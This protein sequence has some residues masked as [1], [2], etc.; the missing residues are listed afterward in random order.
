VTAIT[1][2][3]PQRSGWAIAQGDQVG[4]RAR[5]RL[6]GSRAQRTYSSSMWYSVTS[7]FAAIQVFGYVMAAVC[8]GG[9]AALVTEPGSGCYERLR[10]G[11]W[12]EHSLVTGR[13]GCER[14]K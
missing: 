1:V 9:L 3:E 4:C 2:S 11:S 5:R 8:P 12:S 10:V 7:K 13:S 14:F 6:P